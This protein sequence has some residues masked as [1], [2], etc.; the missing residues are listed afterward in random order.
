MSELDGNRAISL[1][2]KAIEEGMA[3]EARRSVEAALLEGITAKRLLDEA[4]IPA[5]D[6]VGEEYEAGSRYVPEMLIS[7]EAMKA[8][9]EVLGPRLKEAGEEPCG[10]IVLGTV[11]GDLHDIGKDLVG[12]MMEGAG[13]EVIDLGIDVRAETFL[14]A[15]I[16]HKPDLLGMSALLTT[17]ML[18]MEDVTTALS[19]RA[20]RDDVKV[21]VGGAPVTQEYAN[22]IGADGYAS[23]A[24]TAVRIARE[25]VSH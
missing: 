24:A 14:D 1:I 6:R 17:T 12:M 5:M 2:G 21:L 8:C 3:E 25:L 10:R 11:E 23:D 20:L 15:V 18:R 7:A 19:S 9:L 22:E 16:E 4:L 13:F